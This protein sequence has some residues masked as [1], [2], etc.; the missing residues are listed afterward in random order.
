MKRDTGN[1]GRR[2]TIQQ[3][4]VLLERIRAEVERVVE[5]IHATAASLASVRAS[6]RVSEA[7]RATLG[8]IGEA[9]RCQQ[10]ELT[11][12]YGEYESLA[13]KSRPVA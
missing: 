7:D 3:R 4:R 11:R 5:E 9:Q 8:L 2:M 1:M 10:L 13:F 6:D 12:L